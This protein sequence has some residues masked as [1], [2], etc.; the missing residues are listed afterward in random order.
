MYNYFYKFIE[1]FRESDSTLVEAIGTGFR[2][3]YE[4]FDRGGDLNYMGDGVVDITLSDGTNF[5]VDVNKSETLYETAKG[6]KVLVIAPLYKNIRDISFKTYNSKYSAYT[7]ADLSADGAERDPAVMEGVIAVVRAYAEFD[8][9]T[10]SID[11][12]GI[13]DESDDD[14]EIGLEQNMYSSS[15]KL[16]NTI[17]ASQNI[18]S[19]LGDKINIYVRK[20]Q[21]SEID[22]DDVIN[23][24]DDDFRGIE[25]LDE[26]AFNEAYKTVIDIIKH[27]GDILKK[28]KTRRDRAYIL[29]IKR[30]D[31]NA[32][33]SFDGI[34][35]H[36]NLSPELMQKKASNPDL[37]KDSD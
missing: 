14:S 17:N 9:N 6:T 12:N 21:N 15:R 1:S 4:V 33:I 25:K 5:I 27:T 16:L 7:Y 11:F 2:A 29:M 28:G 34:Q 20:I 36:Y 10:A 13:S 24:L 8:P 35:Y 22:V 32:D 3:I 37:K 19:R 31:R 30:R 18:K 26:D 23:I